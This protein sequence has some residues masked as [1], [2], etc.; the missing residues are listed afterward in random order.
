MD[1]ECQSTA[2]CSS[3]FAHEVP[4][5]QT[6]SVLNTAQ[7]DSADFEVELGQERAK[8]AELRREVAEM[9]SDKL[10]LVDLSL[11]KYIWGTPGYVGRLV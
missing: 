4:L 7:N 3:S 1:T 2:P 5:V 11:F 10:R 9:K 8:N 6:S